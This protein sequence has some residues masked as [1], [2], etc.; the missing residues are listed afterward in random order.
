[1]KRL[2]FALLLLAGCGR[3]GPD[4]ERLGDK[5]WHD[6]RWNDAM[7]FYRAAPSSSRVL[8]KLADAAFLA[9]S[10]GVAAEAWTRLGVEEPDRAAEAASG[11]ARTA[12]A[13]ERDNSPRALVLAIAGLRKLE[14]GWPLG[15]L[16]LRL[17]HEPGPFDSLAMSVIPAAL[18]AAPGRTAADSLILALG[19]AQRVAGDCRRAIQTLQS[20]GRRSGGTTTRD[21]AMSEMGW[22]E[23]ALGLRALTA[24]HPAEAESWLDRVAHRD[25]L[26]AVGRRAMVGYG[27]A[28][29]AQGDIPAATLAWQT[30]AA[31]P[32]APDSITVLA[33]ER[34]RIG[35]TAAATDSTR[36]GH[37]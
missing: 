16:S 24:D 34:L 23:L 30:V 7:A 9:G 32:V 14:P 28:R 37:L 27:D 36:Q 19:R 31:A 18:A 21:S 20:A 1:V 11:L 13:A 4:N 12:A 15:R 8:A 10:L 17:A 33:L 25:P 2:A 35:S 5:A 6:G 3:G 22:C 29:L 26:G